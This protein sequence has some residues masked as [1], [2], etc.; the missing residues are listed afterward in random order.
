[1]ELVEGETLGQRL[2]K[3]R[4][5][6]DQV[7]RYGS[8]IADALSG[9][10]V[11]G[12]VHRDLK[13]GNVMVAKTVIK[14]LDFGLARFAEGRDPAA[15]QAETATTGAA[16]V[17][18]PA[19]MAPEQ[20]EGKECDARTDL[21][22]LGLILYEM[23]TGRKA[24]RGESQAALIAEIMRCEPELGELT[25]PQFAHLVERCLAKDPDDRWQ[26]ARDAGLQLEFLSQTPPALQ[27]ATHRSYRLWPVAMVLAA[28]LLMAAVYFTK[29]PEETS[30]VP[31]TSY[32]GIEGCAA[33]PESL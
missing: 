13:P 12:I 19:Y 10:H 5:P 29:R 11:K 8:Q 33:S 26:A 17:G 20:L 14:V 4:I 32:A 21:F 16:I 6:M 9:A 7:L 25:P 23:A 27:A 28:A 24:F 1:M 18:T 2:Q 30:I 22:A 3:G 31:L 15:S